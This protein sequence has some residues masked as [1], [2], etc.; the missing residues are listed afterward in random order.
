[1]PNYYFVLFANMISWMLEAFLHHALQF[2]IQ[3]EMDAMLALVIAAFYSRRK[4]GC[5]RGIP[6]NPF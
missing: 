1:M 6:T 2:Q 5:A 4:V 3:A